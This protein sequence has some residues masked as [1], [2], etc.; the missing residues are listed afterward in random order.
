MQTQVL[1]RSEPR[2]RAAKRTDVGIA[3][4]GY[5]TVGSALARII[6]ERASWLF[7]THGVVLSVRHVTIRD[8]ERER[9]PHVSTQ[10]L[11]RDHQRAL[12]D[13]E[14]NVVVEL[15]GGI[16]PSFA[17][18][19]ATL[20]SGKHLVTANKALIA[21]HGAELENAA[22]RSGALLRYEGAVGGAIPVLR[23][24][25]TS[26]AADH[27]TKVRGI[28]NGTTNYILTRMTE[29]GL[30]FFRALAKASAL[31]FAEADPSFDIS[32]RDAAEKIV[33]LAR[34]AFGEWL[35]VSSVA[36][37]GIERVSLADIEAARNEG[38]ALKLIAEAERTDKGIALSVRMQK[39]PQDNPLAGVRDELNAIEIHSQNAGPIL[40][41]GRGAGGAATAS[42]VYADVVEAVTAQ[43][44]TN[45]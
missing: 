3:L 8:E 39:V 22:E 45:I 44:F 27:I 40:L 37:E 21:A 36:V 34:H 29:D 42:A 32:G 19:Y 16:T 2:P 15:M 24:L 31:G 26:L 6:N 35:P 13:P 28:V 10:L 11:T 14:V 25:R 41:S 20:A 17:L 18:A 12:R 33:I 30:P 43:H 7:N 9:N 4:Y 38:C 5:G 1:L 23:A